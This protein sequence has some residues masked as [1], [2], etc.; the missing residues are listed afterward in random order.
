[1]ALVPFLGPL[2]AGGEAVHFTTDATPRA[3]GF[4]VLQTRISSRARAFHV[5]HARVFVGCRLGRV[6]TLDRTLVGPCDVHRTHRDDVDPR[7]IEGKDGR[8]LDGRWK[9]SGS[10]PCDVL[11]ARSWGEVLLLPMT[12]SARMVPILHYGSDDSM[13]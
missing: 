6:G 12:S 3:C 11:Q 9:G 13:G 2:L 4:V 1:M 7:G 5:R 8:C 10:F